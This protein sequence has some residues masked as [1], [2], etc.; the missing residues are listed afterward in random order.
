MDLGFTSEQDMLRETAAK[1]FVNECPFEKVRE[2][3]ESEKG[4]SPEIWQKMGEHFDKPRCGCFIQEICKNISYDK[5]GVEFPLN[6]EQSIQLCRTEK[7][8]T[9]LP[10]IYKNLLT[11]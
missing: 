8:S 10:K 2:L 5:Q 1:F 6:V 11:N 3:E 9:D 4:Y 7:K